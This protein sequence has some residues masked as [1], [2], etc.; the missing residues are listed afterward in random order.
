MNLGEVGK[1][2]GGTAFP[3][4]GKLTHQGMYL[5]DYFAAHAINAMSHLTSFGNGAW[6]H[7]R[8][9]AECYALADAMLEEREK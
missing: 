7:R 2:V 4:D 5:R 8:I 3:R 6:D 9:A 1:A